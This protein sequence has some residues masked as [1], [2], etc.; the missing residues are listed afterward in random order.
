MQLALRPSSDK[1]WNGTPTHYAVMRDDAMVGR[2]EKKY[3]PKN[4]GG[5]AYEFSY[6]GRH[7]MHASRWFGDINQAKK[8]IREFFNN[9]EYI[10]E[11]MSV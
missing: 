7:G 3:R 1:K 9:G 11:Q 10:Y 8:G 4:C 2:L 5:P 6:I